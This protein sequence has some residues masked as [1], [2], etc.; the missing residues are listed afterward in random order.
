M[1]TADH[2]QRT[3]DIVTR[4]GNEQGTEVVHLAICF[5]EAY[6]NHTYAPWLQ[7][8]INAS[9]EFSALFE[10]FSNVRHLIRCVIT[11]NRMI[12]QTSQSGSEISRVH[13]S[14]LQSILNTQRQTL[15]LP[16]MLNCNL[17]L[18][19]LCT[20]KNLHE[21]RMMVH[22]KGYEAAEKDP[23]NETDV[24]IIIPKLLDFLQH[25]HFC[26]SKI[27]NVSITQYQ[28]HQPSIQSSFQHD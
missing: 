14:M 3:K 21:L 10:T 17:T 28:K 19:D 18:F 6:L 22:I 12:L 15:E 20:H 2:K 9:N 13:S 11:T 25:I 16:I 24:G 23:D 8:K 26:E 4:L 5:V 1:Y 7:I 27:Q